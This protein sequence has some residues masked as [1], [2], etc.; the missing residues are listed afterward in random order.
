[1]SLPNS[2]RTSGAAVRIAGLPDGNKLAYLDSGPVPESND[3]TTLVLLHGMHFNACELPAPPLLIFL[4]PI[5]ILDGF[6]HLLPLAHK[7]NLRLVFL[8][9]RDYSGS[10]KYTDTEIAT[11]DKNPR[12][13]FKDVGLTL[14]RFV[15]YLI[16]NT[17]VC[18]PSED[19]SKGGICIAGWSLGAINATTMF[20]GEGVLD[21]PSYPT[22][23]PYVTT[24]VLYGNPSTLLQGCS[25]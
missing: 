8:Q 14:A 2:C 5:P 21:D 13:F 15:C 10:S 3:F 22:I 7:Y 23:L 25:I 24:L 18:L 4:E 12:V 1:M 6:E 19:R 11:L 20:A 16:Q 17:T 9:R